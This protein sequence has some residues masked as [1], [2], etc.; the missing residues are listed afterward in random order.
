MQ[1]AVTDV[2]ECTLDAQ[3]T[4]VEDAITPHTILVSVMTGE[5]SSR[6][7]L[8]DYLSART[9]MHVSV[10]FAVT[11][12]LPAWS[13]TGLDPIAEDIVLTRGLFSKFQNPLVL[14]SRGGALYVLDLWF[15]H[16]LLEDDSTTAHPSCELKHSLANYDRDTWRNAQLNPSTHPFIDATSAVIGPSAKNPDVFY[17]L[18]PSPG[19]FVGSLDTSEPVPK[20][21]VVISALHLLWPAPST[22]ELRKREDI[23]S[24]DVLDDELMDVTNDGATGNN[25]FKNNGE[26]SSQNGKFGKFGAFPSSASGDFLHSSNEIL[27]ATGSI[28]DDFDFENMASN[29]IPNLSTPLIIVGYNFGTFQIWALDTLEL[30]YCSPIRESRVAVTGFETQSL[31]S[32]ISSPHE[33]KVLLWVSRGS[34]STTWAQQAHAPHISAYGITLFKSGV[35]AIVENEQDENASK[36]DCLESVVLECA[37]KLPSNTDGEY[38]GVV[39]TL[40]AL[41]CWESKTLNNSSLVFAFE[42]FPAHPKPYQIASNRGSS[43]T[44]KSKPASQSSLKPAAFDP[45]DAAPLSHFECHIIS[46]TSLRTDTETLFAHPDQLLQLTLPYELDTLKQ[47]GSQLLGFSVVPSSI[48]HYFPHISS[49]GSANSYGSASAG[50]IGGGSNTAHVSFDAVAVKEDAIWQL[51]YSSYGQQLLNALAEQGPIVFDRPEL[52]ESL[53]NQLDRSLP[54]TD[55]EAHTLRED[56]FSLALHNNLSRVI[57]DYVMDSNVVGALANLKL[58]SKSSAP[59]HQVLAWARANYERVVDTVRT[60]TGEFLVRP[61]TAFTSAIEKEETILELRQAK[62]L[63]NDL[64]N[65]VKALIVRYQTQRTKWDTQEE[66]MQKDLAEIALSTQFI[67]LC[68]W[69][70]QN[71]VHIDFAQFSQ[72]LEARRQRVA[73]CANKSPLAWDVT[74]D[75]KSKQVLGPSGSETTRLTVT[76]KK[77]DSSAKHLLIDHLVATINAGATSESFTFPPTN[78]SNL[79]DYARSGDPMFIALKHQVLYYILLDSDKRLAARF[80]ERVLLTESETKLIRGL[81]AIDCAHF[82]EAM[83]YITD[84]DVTTI[85]TDELA[86]K[87]VKTFLDAR[88]FPNALSLYRVRQPPLDTLESSVLALYVLL[89]NGLMSEAFFHVRNQAR[90]TLDSYDATYLHTL[91]FH[92][93]HHAYNNGVLKDVFQLPFDAIESEALKQYLLWSHA[94]QP[95]SHNQSMQQDGAPR[96]GSAAVDLHLVFLLQRSRVADAVAWYH[97]HNNDGNR[98]KDRD[99]ELMKMHLVNNWIKTLPPVIRASL[100]PATISHQSSQRDVSSIDDE[101]IVA[102]ATR[103]SK[104]VDS[105]A[106]K[107]NSAATPSKRIVTKLFASPQ[108]SKTA[109]SRFAPAALGPALLSPT[110]PGRFIKSPALFRPTIVL[111]SPAHTNAY[112]A[113]TSNAKEAQ[114]SQTM[115]LDSSAAPRPSLFSD[116]DISA[117]LIGTPAKRRFSG[118]PTATNVASE[119]T[120]TSKPAVAVAPTVVSK[121]SL[122][123]VLD[124]DDEDLMIMETPVAPISTPTKKVAD[125]VKLQ[126]D[127]AHR[128]ALLMENAAIDDPDT[129][130]DDDDVIQV[131][132]DSDEDGEEDGEDGIESYSEV[133][134]EDEEELERIRGQS[135]DEEGQEEDEVDDHQSE[136]VSRSSRRS[137]ASA[138]S[139]LSAYSRST[140]SIASKATDRNASRQ[141]TAEISAR[142]SRRTGLRSRNVAQHSLDPVEEEVNGDDTSRAGSQRSRRSEDSKRGSKRRSSTRASSASTQMVDGED[143][144]DSSHPRR[145]TRLRKTSSGTH[146]PPSHAVESAALAS[147]DEEDSLHDTTP[148]VSQQSLQRPKRSSRLSNRKSSEPSSAMAVD[149]ADAAHN[150]EDDEQQHGSQRSAATEPPQPASS[151]RSSRLSRLSSEPMG[152]HPSSYK[153]SQADPEPETE[154]MSGETVRIRRSTRT[155]VSEKQT[156][157]SHIASRTRSIRLKDPRK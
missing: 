17:Y 52:I 30:L 27:D 85:L 64:Y 112:K 82:E 127:E 94:Q 72:L 92:F 21:S 114:K 125:S 151:R 26:I 79:L 150:D 97:Q 137:A 124:D 78:L 12:L 20:D 142:P 67:E 113:S 77:F 25:N 120:T 59:L 130:G 75:S 57:T 66:A 89:G 141:S 156:S 139:K 155:K 93:L 81:H 147:I 106:A 152:V 95:N 51:G 58:Q 28:N 143:S 115:D 44:T 71:S 74:F 2:V 40:K 69:F 7:Y 9:L 60:L 146:A 1:W 16:A 36:S 4:E 68:V 15:D 48:Q 154:D 140:R 104:T 23:D 105:R 108:Q 103:G 149:G 133:N 138:R 144:Q 22:K 119:V 102:T 83:Q 126:A 109:S 116:R 53:L 99:N 107:N 39:H 34:L 157:T 90:T 117:N 37:T 29:W 11:R 110:N 35:E 31:H 14:G 100:K 50:A 38:F 111:G 8:I 43:Q 87:T 134:T 62:R 118:I 135:D 54:T 5:G 121:D 24:M 61:N 33:N 88:A 70:M 96:D 123:T 56:L 86:F 131:D 18:N 41:P 13:P 91:L 10:P 148:H 80:A 73:D 136:T 3:S 45:S 98:V 32:F 46:T 55:E 6:I 47:D 128:Q 63:L 19:E 153:N 76:P 122:I 145:S 84:A 132:L 49:G 101:D 129:W 65:V 42:T